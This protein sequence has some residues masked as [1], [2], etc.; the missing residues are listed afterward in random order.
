MTLKN[1]CLLYSPVPSARRSTK[2][3]SLHAIQPPFSPPHINIINHRPITT[4]LFCAAVQIR[5]VARRKLRFCSRWLTARF[6][7]SFLGL[8]LDISPPAYI[9]AITTDVDIYMHI[10]ARAHTTKHRQSHRHWHRP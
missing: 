7:T 1:V 10:H 5:A 9:M 2:S 3:I 4:L 8:V 6:L